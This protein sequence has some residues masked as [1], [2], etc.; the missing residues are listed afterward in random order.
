MKTKGPGLG[1]IALIAALCMILAASS[2]RTMSSPHE[3]ADDIRLA[4]SFDH[5]DLDF[6]LSTFVDEEGRVNYSAL[7]ND[8]TTL[9]RYV[10]HLAATGP[11]TH[12]ERFPSEADRLAYWLNAYNAFVLFQVVEREDLQSVG[13]SKFLF[14][15][16]TCFEVDGDELNLYDLE[17]DVVRGQFDEPRIH[18]ALNCASVGCPRLPREA[19]QPERLEAQLARETAFF[20]SE[21]RNVEVE[22][23]QVVLSEIFTWFAEDF[24]NDPVAWIRSSAPDIELPT[25][26]EVRYRPWD[27][28]LNGQSTSP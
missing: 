21:S 1:L 15:W 9:D 17:N 22:D 6:V 14:F 13:D 18:F 27:W 24:E 5:A 2:C 26:S 7:R 16:W 28:S 3:L 12:P 25:S 4:E 10:A 11:S 23:G 20:L 19:F 8:R